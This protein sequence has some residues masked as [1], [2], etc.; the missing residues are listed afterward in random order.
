MD[1]GFESHSHC[2]ESHRDLCRDIQ[3]SDREENH[4]N[5]CLQTTESTGPIFDHSDD[6]VQ[7]LRL[8]VCYGLLNE[9][10]NTMHMLSEHFDEIR[11]G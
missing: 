8:S 6:S 4:I 10:Q 7:A 3:I 2:P 5:K 1:K 9:G 11:G